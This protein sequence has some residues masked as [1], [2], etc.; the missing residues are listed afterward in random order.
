MPK[1]WSGYQLVE[2]IRAHEKEVGAP[3]SFIIGLDND[4]TPK[5]LEAAISKG[6]NDAIEKPLNPKLLNSMIASS[7]ERING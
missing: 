3:P 2:N 5:K 6:Y 1:E 7:L 4:L